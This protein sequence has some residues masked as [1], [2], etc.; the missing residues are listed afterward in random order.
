MGPSPGNWLAA[1][2]IFHEN[3]LLTDDDSHVIYLFFSKFEK[4][5]EK[6]S[7]AADD[8]HYSLNLWPQF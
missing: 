6:L 4:N 8:L 7:S 2:M 3:R 5:V 1:H